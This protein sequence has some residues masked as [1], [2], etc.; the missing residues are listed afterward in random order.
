MLHAALLI[1]LNML[2]QEVEVSVNDDDEKEGISMTVAKA[3][4]EQS[5]SFGEVDIQWNREGFRVTI[6]HHKSKV[7]ETD[8][9]FDDL[10]HIVKHELKAY[11]FT[12]E[13]TRSRLT[14]L[15]RIACLPLYSTSP[16]P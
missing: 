16:S 3:L 10:F 11:D 9:G 2:K 6:S 13:G 1:F 12:P 5:T 7:Y 8:G 4:V 14:Q 15:V